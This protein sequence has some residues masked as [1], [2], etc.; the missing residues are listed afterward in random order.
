MATGTVKWFNPAKGYGFIK[1]EDGT[2]DVFVHISAV[3]RAGLESLAEG[4][5]VSFEVTTE[6]GK[7]IGG[8]L[9][10]VMALIDDWQR[11]QQRLAAEERARLEAEARRNREIAE[12]AERKRLEAEAAEVII[13]GPDAFGKFVADEVTKWIKVAGAAGIKGQ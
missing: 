6:R 7:M 11:E 4:Q 12:E 3:E 2:K 13:S 10:K 8:P 5:K 1:P 9:H